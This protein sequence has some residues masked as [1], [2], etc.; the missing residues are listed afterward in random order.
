[1]SQLQPTPPNTLGKASLFLGIIGI[2]FVF[3]VGLCAGVGQQQGWLPVAGPLLFILGGT[4]AFMGLIAAA[5]GL[6][7]LFSRGRATA[8]AG[9]LLGLG[10]VLLFAAIV[11]AVNK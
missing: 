2:V 6:L 7:G 11:N 9:L 5:L 10:T 4:F 3:A 8:I 1:M